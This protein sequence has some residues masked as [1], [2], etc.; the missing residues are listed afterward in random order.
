[1]KPRNLLSADEIAELQEFLER[2][3]ER[4]GI[5]T[6]PEVALRLLELSGHPQAQM[7][8]FAAVIKTDQAMAGRLLRL[9]NSAYF[10]QRVAVT[11]LDRACL[12]LGL[13]RIKAI[14]LGL[15]LTRAAVLPGCKDVSREVWG[16]SVFRACLAA[17]AARAVA[18]ALVPEAFV[19][20]LMLDAGVPL[21]SRLVGDAY[22]GLYSE[23][24]S[25]GTLFRRES[26]TLG[27]NHV[28]VVAA[29]C[30]RWR[31]PELLSR[32]IE[33]HHV[34]PADLRLTEPVHR[35]H[36]IAYVV[37]LM[38][39]DT[40]AAMDGK[41]APQVSGA[42]TTAQRLL[43]ISE[44]ESVA[45]LRRAALEYTAAIEMFTDVAEAITDVEGLVERV[46]VGLV[47][48]I[49]ESVE[50]SI[51]RQEGATPERLVLD[52]QSIELIYAEDD[53]VMAYL[54]DATGQRLLA[55]RFAANDISLEGVCE[56]FGLEVGE[57][58]QREKLAAFL[59]KRAA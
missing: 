14:S 33:L 56:A 1:M 13:D 26:D 22:P 15:Q 5:A 57:G 34:R 3:L 17:E 23:C 52:G 31:L 37:G 11:N 4:I 30:R 2:K 45:F 39:L 28:D 44:S 7:K 10:A 27:F 54:Y 50:T 41:A 36:R 38:E 58:G 51:A 9:A 20:G 35:L 21:M 42:G 48:A 6:R 12:V 29:M 49:D 40:R 47:K 8:E 18:P 43:G 19:V 32:A 46:H 24:P 53:Q 25:P 55:H 59:R 16:Q